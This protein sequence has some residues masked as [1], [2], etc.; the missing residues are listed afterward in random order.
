MYVLRLLLKIQAGNEQNLLLKI[1]SKQMKLLL[2]MTPGLKGDRG[3]GVS[4]GAKS[5]VGRFLPA[6]T[7]VN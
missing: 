3:I 7:P 2:Q 1:K 6:E 4:T 5:S